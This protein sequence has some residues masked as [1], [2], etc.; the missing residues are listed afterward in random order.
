MS[1]LSSFLNNTAIIYT[2]DKSNTTVSGQ[3]IETLVERT[4]IKI[5][6]SP[7]VKNVWKL[8]T[9]G[10]IQVGE[11][12]AYAIKTVVEGE[13]MEI[14]GTKYIVEASNKL[15]AGA[16][17]HIFGYQIYLSRYKH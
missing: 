2:V 17:P 8:F 4:T 5:Y 3:P 13:V 1:C 9:P 16:N 6:F 12:V 14:E 11:F 10:Q 7:H 15:Q